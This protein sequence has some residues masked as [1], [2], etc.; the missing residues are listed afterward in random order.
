ME[1]RKWN[2]ASCSLRGGPNQLIATKDISPTRSAL[3]VILY[4][5]N[6]L[7]IEN[8]KKLNE[9]HLPWYC[10]ESSLRI[11]HS[12]SSELS[13]SSQPPPK[14]S[15]R[16]LQFYGKKG[17]S[18]FS[19]ATRT[20]NTKNSK[21]PR[22]PKRRASPRRRW[23]ELLLASVFTRICLVDPNQL[24]H[25]CWVKMT[26]HIKLSY[27]VMPNPKQ[28]MHRNMRE[29]EDK[30]Q[31]CA[32]ATFRDSFSNVLPVYVVHTST[33]FLLPSRHPAWLRHGHSP[34][35]CWQLLRIQQRSTVYHVHQSSLLE[36]MIVHWKSSDVGTEC[37]HLSTQIKMLPRHSHTNTSCPRPSLPP[38]G[39][40]GSGAQ[41]SWQSSIE[42]LPQENH[43]SQYLYVTIYHYTFNV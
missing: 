39:S 17:S 26:N 18:H 29:H 35:Q 23:Q 24:T 13:S 10:C 25:D 5:L 34:W 41:G 15:S 9:Q 12:S 14:K 36:S 7:T 43:K 20:A 30:N 27:H 37:H 11:R 8:Q 33:P 4:L 28:S 40:W 32:L 38:V 31:N 16:T 1:R 2:F 3:Y 21:E 22:A 42:C 19:L 6:L